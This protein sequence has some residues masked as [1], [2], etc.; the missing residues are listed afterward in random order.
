QINPQTGVI[1]GTPGRDDNGDFTFTITASNG[2]QQ[3]T[4]TA[5]I[6]V[7]DVNKAPTWTPFALQT[8]TAG[9]TMDITATASDEDNDPLTYSLSNAP[10]W[11]MID[12]KTGVITA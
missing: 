11:L 7:E 3:V 2:Q 10:A 9:N 5:Q 12:S 1:S 8:M 4:S 6:V